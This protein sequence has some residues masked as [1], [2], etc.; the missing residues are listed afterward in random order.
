MR[1]DSR[2]LA[3]VAVGCFAI[4]VSLVVNEWLLARFAPDG[5]ISSGARLWLLRTFDLLM[6]GF[7]V[8]CIVFRRSTVLAKGMLAVFAT[9]LVLVVVD[10][11]LFAMAPMLPSATV[12]AM[13]P[14]AQVRFCRANPDVL[15]WVYEANDRHARPNSV[16]EQFGVEYQT[17]SLGYNNPRGFLE[18]HPYVDVLLLGDSFVWGTEEQT[19]ADHM[20]AEDGSVSVYSA[21]IAGAG[22]PQWRHNYLRFVRE[23]S[24]RVPPQAA[25]LNF[26]S[27]ND[28]ADTRVFQLIEARD[29][30]VDS[31]QYYA[32]INHHYLLPRE[33][34]RLGLPKPPELFFLLTYLLSA[35]HEH[36]SGEPRTLIVDGLELPV[37]QRLTEP[38]VWQMDNHVLDEI[39]KTVQAI[40]EVKRDTMI[41]LSYIPTSSGIYGDLMAPACPDRSE[42]PVR[43]RELSA[44]LAKHAGALGISYADFTA[45]LRRLNTTEPVWSDNNHFS[46]AGYRLYAHLL[47]EEIRRLMVTTMAARQ[48]PQD[49]GGIDGGRR[50]QESQDRDRKTIRAALDR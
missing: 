48:P 49:I 33:R 14:H 16:V 41:L 18:G 45:S 35:V 4:L 30:T 3:L 44:A 31:A 43:Q 37:C 24:G 27:G 6:F 15:S 5:E 19:L 9:G 32:F 17:D 1:T 40:R 28:I 2:S 13:S 36:R 12:A 38:A 22:I 29:G 47:F 46:P 50:I 39:D 21:G 20:R 8:I 25:V 26:F 11:A 10:C 23:N 7:G 42:D 34:G